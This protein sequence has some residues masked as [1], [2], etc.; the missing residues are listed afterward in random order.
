MPR[1][2]WMAPGKLSMVSNPFF[3]KMPRNLMP[4]AV[5]IR[6]GPNEIGKNLIFILR[7]SLSHSLK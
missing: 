6:I 7:S 2:S 4:L 5:S 1:I 3:S